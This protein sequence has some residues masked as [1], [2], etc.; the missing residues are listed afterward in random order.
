MKIDQVWA[1]DRGVT[2]GVRRRYRAIKRQGAEERNA[3]TLP[4]RRRQ[5]RRRRGQ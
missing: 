4:E 3:R 5:A 1:Q 2:P